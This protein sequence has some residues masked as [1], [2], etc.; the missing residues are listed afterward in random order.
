MLQTWLALLL[1]HRIKNIN[2]DHSQRPK[3]KLYNIFSLELAFGILV[4]LTTF[5]MGQLS[6]KDHLTNFFLIAHKGE[7]NTSLQN[8][9]ARD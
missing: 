6:T 5:I 9:Y 7:G 8:R 3:V 1:S 2:P 4:I